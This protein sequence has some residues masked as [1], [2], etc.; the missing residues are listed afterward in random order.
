[1]DDGIIPGCAGGRRSAAVGWRR[2]GICG[3]AAGRVEE[4][5]V[6]TTN[7]KAYLRERKRGFLYEKSVVNLCGVRRDGGCDGGMFLL[8]QG[9]RT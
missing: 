8:F 3:R 7:P 5:A 4:L 2:H 6:N 9:E 1:M